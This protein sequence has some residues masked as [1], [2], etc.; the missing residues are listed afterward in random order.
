MLQKLPIVPAQV[1]V[2]NTSK[3]LLNEIFQIIYFLYGAKEITKKSMLQYNEFSKFTMQSWILSIFMDSEKCKTCEPYRLLLNLSDK[4][5]LKRTDKYV[6]FSNDSISYTWKN[7]K[8][9]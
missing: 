7:I 3:N 6:V 9:T 2:D 8:K 4:I 1:K 5:N